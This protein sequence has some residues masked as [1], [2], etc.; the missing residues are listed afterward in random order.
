MNSE[1]EEPLSS[2]M[3]HIY[4][5]YFDSG[6]LSR[7]LTMISSLR[8][9][10]DDAPVVVLALD[11][12]VTEFFASNPTEGVDV[13][14]IARIEEIHPE[15][16]ELKIERTR[17]EYY[18]TC[19][20]LLIEY[21]MDELGTPGALAIYLDADLFFFDEPS[22]VI[23]ALAGKSVGIIEHRYPLRQEKKLAK[24]GRFNVGWLGF[25]DDDDGR[26][27]LGWY[28][29][30]TLEWCSDKPDDGRYADQGYLDWF[31]EFS[32][33]RVLSD[34]GFNL[35]PW[36]TARHRLT[37]SPANMVLV[38]GSPL[39]FFHFH[40][41]RQVGQWYTTSQLIY[42]SWM[43]RILRDRVYRPY[44]DLLEATEKTV[45]PVLT[46]A[47]YVNKRGTGM[48][49]LISRSR[50]IIFDQISILTGNAIRVFAP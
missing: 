48:L 21:V 36:N 42:G 17:M 46:N 16:L 12:A 38:D 9:H 25:R 1:I 8:A 28:S 39:T 44:I 10:G 40:G 50:K 20:P 26:T 11:E 49:G 24:Y 29:N 41:V 22:R 45:A 31:P 4:C 30:K 15:L 34:A 35:A 47:Q 43:T 19:T 7:A 37:F 23:E 27:V 2:V 5:T 18:F 13:I 32:G 14:S 3:D 33:V 6:Y